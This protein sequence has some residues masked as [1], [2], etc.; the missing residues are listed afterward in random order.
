VATVES[1]RPSP[2]R[3]SQRLAVKLGS[4]LDPE[5][6]IFLRHREE[7]R[8]GAERGA[9]VRQRRRHNSIDDRGPV[10]RLHG[11]DRDEVDRQTENSCYGKRSVEAGGLTKG[12][13]EAR[14]PIYDASD[15][16]GCRTGQ[17]RNR[18]KAR[19]NDPDASRPREH[20]YAD[21]RECGAR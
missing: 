9:H 12:V 5:T 4:P 18:E 21:R 6:Q 14:A 11:I 19:A 7:K 1:S 2:S 17:N 3:R 20:D 8:R 16:V 15:R 10:K 13:P